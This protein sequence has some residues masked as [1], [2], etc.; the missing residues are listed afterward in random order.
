M[1]PAGPGAGPMIPRGHV[2]RSRWEEIPGTVSF[3]L[4]PEDGLPDRFAPGQ[5]SMLYVPGIG[6][7]PISISGDPGDGGLLRHTIRKVGAVTAALGE[8]VPG[9][10]VGVRG[11]FGVG[12]PVDAARGGDLVLVAGGIGMAP[13]RPAVLAVLADRAAFGR[14]AL[15]YGAR[16]PEE[17]L[18]A[19]EHERWSAGGIEIRQTVDHAREGWAG[20]VGMV[21]GLI[22]SV[23]VDGPTAHAFVC[24]P[25]VMMRAVA[26]SLLDRGLGADRIHLSMERNMKCGIGHCGH[27]Q[28]GPVFACREGP[29][30][31]LERA[32]RLLAVPEI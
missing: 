32:T 15:L 18:F 19:E 21:T 25:E 8:V 1:S 5:F 7:V 22:P 2:V 28:V 30:L 26:A 24:G 11:P 14:V 16:S 31:T 13:L 12:W 17:R 9:D 27:C 3:D 6:E 4:V 10:W 23:D 29:V 20:R